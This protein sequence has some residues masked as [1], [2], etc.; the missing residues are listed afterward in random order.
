[1]ISTY[2][3]AVARTMSTIC[4]LSIMVGCASVPPSL[5][6]AAL[7][8][9]ERT[10]T[11]AFIPQ[12]EVTFQYMRSSYGAAFGLVGA[13]IDAGVTGVRAKSAKTKGKELRE[14][15]RD[16]DVRSA[17]WNSI[18]NTLVET[19]WLKVCDM[20]W[21][22]TNVSKLRPAEVTNHSVMNIGTSYAISA[23]VRVLQ[24]TT[25][26]DMYV[27]G[28][29]KKPAA[30]VVMTSYSDEIGKEEGEKALALWTAEEGAALRRALREGIAEHTRMLRL[31]LDL[32]G[33]S[34]NTTHR[35]A[36]ILARL[37]HGRAELGTPTSRQPLWGAIVDESQSRVTFRTNKG[38]LF[39]FAKSEVEVDFSESTAPKASSPKGASGR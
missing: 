29:H 31:A 24:L 32:M 10:Q 7:A 15:V 27:P 11:R 36:K 6:P 26:I 35:P 9:I 34:T 12:S 37:V 13:V 3:P 2:L 20:E 18:S 22:G 39:S 4:A 30:S 16:W 25:G 17:Y 8:Q 28:K 1:M 5:P 21:L 33:G 38:L 23:D 14:V 19:P